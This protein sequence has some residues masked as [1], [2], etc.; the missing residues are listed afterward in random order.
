VCQFCAKHGDGKKWYLQAKSYAADLSSD[1]RRREFITQFARDFNQR[2]SRSV[3]KMELLKKLPGGLRRL[4]SR[5]ASRRLEKTHFGQPVPME[6]CAKVFDITTSIVRVP[7]VCRNFS[8]TPD[9]GYCLLITTRPAQDD[10]LQPLSELASGPDVSAFESLSKEDALALLGQCESEGLM[11][12]VWTF[13]TPFIA[14]MCNCSLPAGCMAM[15]AQLDYGV[16]CM[17]KGEYVAVVSEDLC[18]GCGQC[19]DACPFDAIELDVKSRKAVVRLS[20]CYG[21]GICRAACPTGA[22]G[23]RERQLVAEVAND[24]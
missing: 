7:C 4:V 8:Q 1:L 19:V 13:Y 21:C 6:D 12:S 11:H 10:L 20:R 14:A 23:L 15:R 3:K 24:W 22:A 16:K 17:W 9:K 5:L 2:M 18:V